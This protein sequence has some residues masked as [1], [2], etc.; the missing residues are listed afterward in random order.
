MPSEEAIINEEQSQDQD[1]KQVYKET[2]ITIQQDSEENKN[3]LD[4]ENI[5]Q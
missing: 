1:K 4:L 3:E 5:L 2:A